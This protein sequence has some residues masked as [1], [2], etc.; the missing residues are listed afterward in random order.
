MD[1][2]RGGGGRGSGRGR[3]LGSVRVRSGVNIS[4]CSVCV[5]GSRLCDGDAIP[6]SALRHRYATADARTPAELQHRTSPPLPV[7]ARHDQPLPLC[8]SAPPPPR[9]SR[10]TPSARKRRSV[11]E[12]LPE[13]SSPA[14]KVSGILGSESRSNSCR[15]AAH[16]QS[17]LQSS[18]VAPANPSSASSR[19]HLGRQSRT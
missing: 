19:S 13:A 3:G 7:L 9:V 5:E 4:P 12:T 2:G 8:V 17:G 14:T 15:T 10:A 1:W 18:P 16:E 11:R 6:G